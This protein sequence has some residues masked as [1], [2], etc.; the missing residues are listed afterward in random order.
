MVLRKYLWELE[1]R[2]CIL[3]LDTNITQLTTVHP[4][5]HDD[6]SVVSAGEIM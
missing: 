6:H 5:L 4:L 3:L 2:Y 1:K